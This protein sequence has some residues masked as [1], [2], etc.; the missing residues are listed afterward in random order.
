MEGEQAV[1]AEDLV[2]VWAA[3]HE[4]D[5][6]QRHQRAVERGEL[7]GSRDG[8]RQRTQLAEVPMADP[9]RDDEENV[10]GDERVGVSGGEAP[11]PWDGD[12]AQPAGGGPGPSRGRT[13]KRF[14]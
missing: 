7:P 2:E 10:E 1:R 5:L 13:V 6:D 9:Q 14:G 12:V 3:R 8:A 11:R 4:H